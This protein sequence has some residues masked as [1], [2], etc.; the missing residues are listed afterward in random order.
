[1]IAYQCAGPSALQ[2]QRHISERP[3]LHSAARALTGSLGLR[4]PHIGRAG[5]RHNGRKPRQSPTVSCLMLTA[6]DAESRISL[7]R[8]QARQSWPARRPKS[9]ARTGI[10]LERSSGNFVQTNKKPACSRNGKQ[11]RDLAADVGL[12]PEW[13][14]IHVT[15]S[16]MKGVEANLTALSVC[17]SQIAKI[18]QTAAPADVGRVPTPGWRQKARLQE[19]YSCNAIEGRPE[20]S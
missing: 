19:K 8:S 14:E 16:N 20:N 2:K 4:T 9:Y 17:K 12:C 1:M 5:C 10:N 11:N 3:L 7:C 15:A 18:G 13:L 6:S